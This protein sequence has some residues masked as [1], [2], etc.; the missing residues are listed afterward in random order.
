MK[1]KSDSIIFNLFSYIIVGIV[2]VSCLL[3][4]YVLIVN[5][6]SSENSIVLHGYRFFPVEFSLAAYSEI[7][8]AAEY[9]V[10][11]SYKITIIRTVML[12]IIS[13][14]L[15]SMAA[16]TLSRKDVKYRNKLA[17]YL[18]FTMLFSGGLVPS[19]ILNVRYFHL[20]NTFLILLI[21][22]LLSVPYIFILRTYI[23]TSISDALS[24][25]AKIEG[26]NDFMIFI[27]IIL[28]LM[29][30][31]LASIGLFTAIGCWNDWFTAML[32]ID[33]LKLMPLQYMLYR[34][35]SI[36]T[37]RNVNDLPGGLVIRMPEETLKMAMTAVVTGPIIF[38][39]PFVQRYFVTGITLGAVKS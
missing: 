39:Y 11:N 12:T 35:L 2:A 27:K 3:P 17:F 20:K 1:S 36:V 15:S 29:K 4:F 13:L 21:A 16:Y 25:A 6:F 37:F 38:L 24:E 34:I 8:K 18:F 10:L 5:S 9:G 7:F 23:T 14:L 32:Y 26:A 30:P 33:D 31:S 22:G 19:Y 28:P